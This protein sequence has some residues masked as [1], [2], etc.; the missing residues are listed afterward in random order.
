MVYACSDV[1]RHLHFGQNDQGLLRAIEVNQSAQKANSTGKEN[2]PANPAGDSNCDSTNAVRMLCGHSS[3][4]GKTDEH[5]NYGCLIPFLSFHGMWQRNGM[6]G[7]CGFLPPPPPLHGA[8]PA[9][10]ARPP[11]RKIDMVCIP[12]N[13]FFRTLDLYEQLGLLK[14]LRCRQP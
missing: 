9:A 12:D 4:N 14:F 2:S 5:G 7:R 3:D 6:R 8:I 10:A 11:Q 1:T 13:F